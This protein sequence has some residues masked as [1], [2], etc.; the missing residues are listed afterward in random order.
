METIFSIA[1]FPPVEF[2]QITMKSDLLLMEATENYQKQSYRNRCNILTANG[3][4]PLAV[5]V[6]HTHNTAIREV[7]IDHKTDWQR[8]HWRAIESAYNGSPYFQYYADF[9]LPF[10]EKKYQF[11]FD[12][13]MDILQTI[14]KLLKIKTEIFYT[15]RYV[16]NYEDAADYRQC[17]HPKRNDE[18]D[19]PLRI[20]TPYPQVFDY[21]FGFIP[22]L[23]IMDLIFNLGNESLEYLSNCRDMFQ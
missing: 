7:R 18:A 10:F 23:S 8:K 21:K 11:L 22:N 15:D 17:I 13:N 20:F 14:C 12:Y 3:V 5:P 2:F 1:F 19:Y 16:K 4:L 9:F 6:C